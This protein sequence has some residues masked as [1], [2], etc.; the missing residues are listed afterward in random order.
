MEKTEITQ[1]T[2]FACAGK[3]FL[4]DHGEVLLALVKY[5]RGNPGFSLVIMNTNEEIL[6]DRHYDFPDDNI[7][8]YATIFYNESLKCLVLEVCHNANTRLMLINQ[9]TRDTIRNIVLP[10]K[11]PKQIRMNDWWFAALF[12]ENQTIAL[13]WVNLETGMVRQPFLNLSN[14]V[15]H[16][17]LIGDTRENTYCYLVERHSGKHYVLW[18]PLTETLAEYDIPKWEL[19]SDELSAGREGEHVIFMGSW[20][21][22]LVIVGQD[23]LKRPEKATLKILVLGTQENGKPYTGGEVHL[24]DYHAP[25]RKPQITD[26]GY[27][28]ISHKNICGWVDLLREG[29]GKSLD[30][31]INTQEPNIEK[32]AWV[33]PEN[34][35]PYLVAW[36][37]A[38]RDCAM[39]AII[40]NTHS[41]KEVAL[42]ST[43]LKIEMSTEGYTAPY[44]CS[45][46]DH[47]FACLHGEVRKYIS[48]VKLN[49]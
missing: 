48:Y 35:P 3:A 20:K 42:R 22:Y 46:K 23:Q 1:N 41:R 40:Y 32:F 14:K 18:F 7:V 2:T 17:A 9:D 10:K 43:G 13:F 30:G 25:I 12:V 28:L 38:A 5:N 44:F 16:I 6:F 47:F 34:G 4:N 21:H 11:D 37:C 24:K 26:D 8:N 19:R 49:V 45:L 39:Y 33:K 15:P 27:L 31:E 36:I 29:S